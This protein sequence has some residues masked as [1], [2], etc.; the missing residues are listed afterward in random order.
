MKHLN[1]MA[2]FLTLGSVTAAHAAPLSSAPYT[3]TQ[4]TDGAAVFA[5]NCAMCHGTPASDW[6]FSAARLAPMS[7][8]QIFTTMTTSM[9][10]NNPGGLSHTQYE[11]ILAYILQ[12]NG[13]P[14]GSEPLDYNQA[15]KSQTPIA[16]QK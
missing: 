6:A 13:Y 9:P 14:A 16:Q 3:K 2:F 1:I 15:L 10:R 8:G 11:D 7:V 12:N 4:A 5:Q